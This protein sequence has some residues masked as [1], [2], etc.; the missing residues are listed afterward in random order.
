MDPLLI[1][2]TLRIAHL[3]AVILAMGAAFFADWRMLNAVR[4]PVTPRELSLVDDLHHY[5]IGTL[6]L[7]WVTGL[8][9]VWLRTG[10]LLSD[11]SPKLITKLI[12]VTLL[13]LNAVV[14]GTLALPLLRG[15]AGA[16]PLQFSLS[17]KMVLGTVAGIS[18]ASWLLALALGGSKVLAA[19][20]WDVLAPLLTSTYTMAIAA[21]WAA[22]GLSHWLIAGRMQHHNPF[23][24]LHGA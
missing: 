6:A 21:A 3:F 4:D 12:T 13:S 14:I 5:V 18:T 2:D 19:S 10:F 1:S 15:Q 11:F 20:D 22:A 8:G 9:L 7:V 23:H 24:R 16:S 17:H